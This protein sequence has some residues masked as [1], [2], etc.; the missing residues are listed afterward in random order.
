MTES[1]PLTADGDACL[2]AVHATP[3]APK[4]AI[5][6]IERDAAGRIWLRVRVTAAPEDGKANKAV[7]RLLS[8]SWGIPASHFSVHSGDAA[9][10]KRLRILCDYQTLAKILHGF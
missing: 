5:D 6:G 8:K 3:R 10:Y 7:I 2:L 1:F 9:R 4:N